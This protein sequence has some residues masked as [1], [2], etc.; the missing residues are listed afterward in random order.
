MVGGQAAPPTQT[1]GTGCIMPESAQQ[2]AGGVMPAAP[3]SQGMGSFN[4]AVTPQQSHG[5]GGVMPESTHQGQVP[6]NTPEGASSPTAKTNSKKDPSDKKSS[7]KKS[8]S[9]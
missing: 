4:A 1:H 9:K 8:G 7:S 2:F 3:Q 5:T 6:A